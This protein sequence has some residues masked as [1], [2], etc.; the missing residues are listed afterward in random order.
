[1]I[2]QIYG[3]KTLADA[4][5]LVRLGVD[6][7]GLEVASDATDQASMKQIVD[8]I[9]DRIA[10]VLLPLF[11][12]L[13]A[14]LRLVREFRPDV[15]H[16]CSAEMLPPDEARAF[17]AELGGAKLLQAVPVGLPGRSHEIDSPG[18]ALAYQEVADIILLDTYA[19]DHAAGSTEIPG[20]IGVTGKT[21][22]WTVSRQIVARCRKPVILAG[23]LTPKNVTAALKTVRPWGVDSHTGTNL[24]QGKKDLKKVKAFVQ[25]IRNWEAE[26]SAEWIHN[27]GDTES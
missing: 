9:Y 23:G 21:H 20:W 2:V 3:T 13:D 27:H 12:D 5:A 4:K 18:L 10:T 24:H 15:L 17:R 11:T 14:I 7:L 26:R 6:Y 8:R 16:L 25:A 19:G 22:D 1:M